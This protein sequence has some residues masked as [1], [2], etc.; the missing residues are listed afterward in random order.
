MKNILVFVDNEEILQRFKELTITKALEKKR[1]LKFEYAYSPRNPLFSK[2]FHTAD[3]IKPILIKENIDW[4]IMKYELVFSLHSKQIFP[5]ELVKKIR[6]INIHPGLNPFNRGWFP[7]VF[8]II[9]S[10]PCGA[11][12]HEI[13]EHLDH[14]PIICQKEVRVEEHDTSL[15]TYNK[16]LDAESELISKYLESIINGNYTTHVKGKGNLNKKKDY[17]KLC[18]IDLYDKDTFKNHINKLRALTHGNYSNA[19][20]KDESGNKIFLKLELTKN[21]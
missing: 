8:S 10:L 9:N 2:K 19:Y 3:W 4:I 11:T 12:I 14:G 15:S 13:D 17:L 18:E 16:I 21:E 5:S 1:G 20:F 7:H 6:C